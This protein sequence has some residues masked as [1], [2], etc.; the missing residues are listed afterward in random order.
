MI[1]QLLVSGIQEQVSW[2]LLA[3]MVAAKLLSRAASQSRLH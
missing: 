3:Y 2:V 1:S